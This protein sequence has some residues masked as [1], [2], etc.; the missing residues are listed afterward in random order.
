[1]SFNAY[2]SFILWQGLGQTISFISSRQNSLILLKRYHYCSSVNPG[3]G[4]VL[5]MLANVACHGVFSNCISFSVS[6]QEF[7]IYIIPGLLVEK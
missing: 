5:G 7:F 3:G 4:I 6:L 2:T 1:M